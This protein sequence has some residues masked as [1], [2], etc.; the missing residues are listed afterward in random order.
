M[1]SDGQVAQIE[2]TERDSRQPEAE[3]RPDLEAAREPEPEPEPELEPKLEMPPEGVPD[4][5]KRVRAKSFA[6]MVHLNRKGTLST[7][8]EPTNSHQVAVQAAQADSWLDTIKS[9][10]IARVRTR[11]RE[12]QEGSKHYSPVAFGAAAWTKRLPDVPKHPLNML[13]TALCGAHVEGQRKNAAGALLR[14]V[15]PSILSAFPFLYP[16]VRFVVSGSFGWR[17]ELLRCTMS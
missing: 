10:Q 15:L 7:D 17:E 2:R 12:T 8:S 4:D 13:H 5:T 1:L 6:D 9:F 11:R 16:M 3:P 14:V